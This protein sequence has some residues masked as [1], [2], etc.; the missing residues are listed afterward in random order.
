MLT[1]T[2]TFP[3]YGVTNTDR[4]QLRSKAEPDTWYSS[5]R[6]LLDCMEIENTRRQCYLNNREWIQ[7]SAYE[8]EG[9]II[10]TRTYQDHHERLINY[11]DRSA[12]RVP[13]DKTPTVKSEKSI[14]FETDVQFEI[15]TFKTT[16]EDNTCQS[17]GH[18]PSVVL[19]CAT[20]TSLLLLRMPRGCVYGTD[21]G[22]RH[23]IWSF[24]PK[25]NLHWRIVAKTCGIGSTISFSPSNSIFSFEFI[26]IPYIINKKPV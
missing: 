15:A 24:G 14:Q 12:G 21:L 7:C 9:R 25:R 13:I 20:S 23:I 2:P 5:R 4:T 16:H 22:G 10:P 17:W 11:W 1:S 18:Q 8:P 26:C 3:D 19:S 6:R